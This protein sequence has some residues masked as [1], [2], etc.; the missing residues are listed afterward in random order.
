VLISPS[1]LFIM[2]YN[3]GHRLTRAEEPAVNEEL[4]R[5]GREVYVLAKALRPRRS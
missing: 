5:R 2:E 4:K 1:N 3:N